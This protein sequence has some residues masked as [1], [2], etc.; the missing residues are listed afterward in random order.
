MRPKDGDATAVAGLLGAS[1]IVSAVGVPLPYRTD[2]TSVHETAHDPGDA[3]VW[4][5]LAFV[6]ARVRLLASTCQATPTAFEARL[7]TPPE[8]LADG[9]R[10]EMG[11]DVVGHGL[12]RVTLL[13]ATPPL[14]LHS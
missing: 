12:A 1:E 8:E 10:V 3:K 6:E 9:Q 14:H 11:V 4:D 13:K 7:R 2:V 5:L